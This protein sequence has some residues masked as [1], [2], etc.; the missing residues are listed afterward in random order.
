MASRGDSRWDDPQARLFLHYGDLTDGAGL[1]GVL[2][3]CRPDEVY[4]LGAQSHVR[5]SF[6]Q[7]VFTTQVDFDEGLRRMI[8]WYRSEMPDEK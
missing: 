6:D 1:R 8:D 2:T 5:F 7:P 4:N 3:K